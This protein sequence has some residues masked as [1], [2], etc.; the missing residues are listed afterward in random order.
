MDLT[1]LSL[2]IKVFK[3]KFHRAVSLPCITQIHS[4]PLCLQKWREPRE[5]RKKMRKGRTLQGQTAKGRTL[6]GQMALAEE[7]NTCLTLVRVPSTRARTATAPS[8]STWGPSLQVGHCVWLLRWI[9]DKLSG[10][11][12]WGAYVVDSFTLALRFVELD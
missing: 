7:R 5:G 2:C 10:L 3:F 11:M 1:L 6:Q 8:A 12:D 9:Y 4:L